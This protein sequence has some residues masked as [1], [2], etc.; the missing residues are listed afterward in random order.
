MHRTVP[1]ENG[2]MKMGM[3]IYP[4]GDGPVSKCY[5]CSTVSRHTIHYRNSSTKMQVV[6]PLK[7]YVCPGGDLPPRNCKSGV[8]HIVASRGMDACVCEDRWFGNE[9]TGCQE[10]PKGYYCVDGTKRICADDTYQDETSATT[11]KACSSNN[12]R[13]GK[14]LPKCL[15]SIPGSQ[16]KSMADACVDCIKCRRHYITPVKGQQDCYPR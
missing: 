3:D 13:L 9:D 8:A 7:P 15:N 11:C 6:N 5:D 1:E 14:E 10:C 2:P 12:C 4:I 16:D